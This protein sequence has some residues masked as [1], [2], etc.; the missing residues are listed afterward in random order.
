MGERERGETSDTLSLVRKKLRKGMSRDI[1]AYRV[2]GAAS[3]QSTLGSR[4][5]NM[6]N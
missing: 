2:V 6:C 1:P 3:K 5:V 4:S